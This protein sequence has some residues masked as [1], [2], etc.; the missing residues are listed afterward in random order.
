MKIKYL[1]MAA[2]VALAILLTF[3][4]G[5]GGAP[6]VP[7]S[8]PAATTPADDSPQAPSA[9]S[10]VGTPVPRSDVETAFEEPLSSGLS[11]ADVVENALPSVVQIVAGSG[12]GTGFIINESGLA[13]TNRHVVEGNR[14]VILRQVTGEEYKGDVT[15]RHPDLDLAYIE[16]D[17][18]PVVHSYRNWRLRRNPRRRGCYR[19]RF[20][21]GPVA[22]L[23]VNPDSGELTRV[24]TT[25]LGNNPGWISIVELPR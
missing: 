8:R 6:G 11:V 10:V 15:F 1:L 16:I 13:V 18:T 17:A 2:V 24:E 23:S 19:H 12:T 20:P 21:I 4:C 14:Q 5:F 22:G 25:P 7:A 9:S 3:A